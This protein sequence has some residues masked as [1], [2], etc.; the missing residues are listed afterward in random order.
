MPYFKADL[1][2]HT[3]TS[4]CGSLEMSPANIVQ[5]ALNKQLDIIAITDHNCT[6]QAALVMKLGLAKGL[7][8]IGGAEITTSEEV[9][10]LVYFEAYDQLVQFQ[11]FIDSSLPPVDNKPDLFGHQVVV[12]EA[13]MIV[14]ELPY[15]LTNSLGLTL[16]E[17]ERKVH[18]MGGLV[19]P[20]H[21]DRPY[22]GLYS[23]LGFLPDN[24]HPDAFELSVH[25][26][27][28]WKMNGK[29][30]L[31]SAILHSSDAHY[32]HQIGTAFTLFEMEA[33]SFEEI[34]LAMSFQ[35]GRRVVQ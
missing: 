29:I 25:A 5:I 23:Q 3:L 31:N 8:V 30:P 6:K 24:F 34:K 16:E 13:E 9:H 35:Q 21:V 32:P 22:N 7:V 26:S 1:H 11:D 18:S 28:S 2:I 33:P 4:P 10:C 19:V 17:I 20:A 12:D 14:E 15:L 27:H